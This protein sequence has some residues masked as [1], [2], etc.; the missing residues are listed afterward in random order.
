MPHLPSHILLLTLTLFAAALLP[1]CAPAQEPSAPTETAATGQDAAAERVLQRE[2]DRITARADSIDVIFQLLPLLRPAEES[3]LRRFGNQAQLER[4]RA[5]G[6]GPSPS[7]ERLQA[8]ERDE[9]LVRLEQSTEHWIVRELDYSVPLVVPSVE[10][11]L[12]EIGERFHAQLDDLGVPRYRLEVTS[13][14]RSAEN[15]AALRRVN[16]NAAAGVSTHQFGTTIDIAYSAFAAPQEPIVEV[17][18]AE[19]PWL[20]PHLHRFAAAIAETVAARR[21][22]ELQAVLGRVLIEM[23]QEGKVMVTLE[24][25]QPVYHVTVARRL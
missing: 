8:L 25:L 19:A 3:V 15:Q 14:L 23:Q 1:G 6:I 22:R 7:A 13:G 18:A 5:L 20:E 24:R 17:D 10:V 11:L 2:L 12:T 4:A 9:Q 21:S 16:P